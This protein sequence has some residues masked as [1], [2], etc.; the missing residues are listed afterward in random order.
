MKVSNQELKRIIKEEL[1]R[2]LNESKRGSVPDAAP[3]L[4]EGADYGAQI[5]EIFNSVELIRAKLNCMAHYTDAN[6]SGAARKL[7]RCATVK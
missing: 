5:A 1:H 4:E 3:V 2:A 7:K 6:A